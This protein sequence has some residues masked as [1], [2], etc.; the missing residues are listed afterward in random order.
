MDIILFGSG[1]WVRVWILVK[2]GWADS[3]SRRAMGI[4][5]E[6]WVGASDART[7]FALSKNSCSVFVYDFLCGLA[8]VAVATAAGCSLL[9]GLLSRYQDTKTELVFLLFVHE[10]GP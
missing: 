9:F 2:P 8:S 3:P 6:Q 4:T 7:W 1:V 10:A 5:T